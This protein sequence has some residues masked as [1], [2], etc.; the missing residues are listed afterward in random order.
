MREEIVIFVGIVSLESLREMTSSAG[1][2]SGRKSRVDLRFDFQF[3]S[4]QIIVHHAVVSRDK[5]LEALSSSTTPHSGTIP[6][7]ALRSSQ[8]CF[9]EK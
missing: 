9:P 1:T 4:A 2:P 7:A 5:L 8:I 6:Y 3:F